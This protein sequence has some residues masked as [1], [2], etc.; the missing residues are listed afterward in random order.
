[1]PNIARGLPPTFVPSSRRL[2]AR[3]GLNA[4]Q[5]EAIDKFQ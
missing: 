2:V 1:M 5:S 3:V 4:S